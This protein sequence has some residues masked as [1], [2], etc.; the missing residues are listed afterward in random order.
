MMVIGLGVFLDEGFDI[1]ILDDGLVVEV[2]VY[3]EEWWVVLEWSVV[4]M[5]LIFCGLFIFEYNMKEFE[6]NIF[7]GV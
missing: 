7:F 2:I 3:Y 6:D 1:W 4:L 5:D